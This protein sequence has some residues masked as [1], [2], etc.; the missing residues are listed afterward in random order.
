[1]D[2]R[3]FLHEYINMS[4]YVALGTLDGILAV[5]GVTLTASGVAGAGGLSVDN[6]LIALTGL[7]GGVALAMSNAF[8]S[9]IGERAEETRTMRELE[10]KMMMDEGKLDDTIIHQQA[11]RRVYMSMFTHGFSSFMG[12]F[13]PV[14]PFLVIADRMTATI[15]TVL[16]C[17]I[18]LLVLGVY[19]GRVSRENILRTS[20]EVVVIGVLIGVVSLLLGGSH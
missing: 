12:S 15:V 3:G 17:L 9:F 14:L 11:R 6:Y 5:M 19:L 4:R 13:V 10:R 8:G 2:I 1:M 16:L 18:A 20:L 7:S